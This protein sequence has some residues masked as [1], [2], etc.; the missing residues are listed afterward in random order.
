MLGN[1][2]TRRITLTAQAGAESCEADRGHGG[3]STLANDAVPRSQVRSSEFARLR[4]RRDNF[5]FAISAAAVM[6]A[7]ESGAAAVAAPA[8]DHA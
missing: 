2:T 1:E 6:L 3:Q 8:L 4:K 5:G 7:Q